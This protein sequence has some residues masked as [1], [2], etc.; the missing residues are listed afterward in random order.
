MLG[1][2]IQV[3][4]F[5]PRSRANGPGNR[6]VLWFQGCT[7]AC[8]GCY[9]PTTH[10]V[11]QNPRTV[12]EIVADLATLTDIEGIT[13]S[14]GEPFQQVDG[15]VALLA[16]VKTEL[17]HLSVVI[18]T[19][20]TPNEWL[21]R[22]P[23]DDALATV[24]ECA[25]VVIAGR[26]NRQQRIAKGLRASANKQFQFLSDRY[27]QA[28]FARIPTAEVIISTSGLVTLTGINPLQ[29]R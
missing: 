7:L 14:G 16:A 22:L 19:G 20:Y 11:T 6:A 9:N 8:P 23:R 18:F 12:G 15:L 21:R 13:I 26:Y 2:T 1:T 28:D 5:E 25:D 3:H 24:F 4:G 29:V 10:S 17:P 27:T